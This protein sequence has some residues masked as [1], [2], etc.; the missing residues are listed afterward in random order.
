LAAPV[1][2]GGR[3]PEKLGNIGLFRQWETPDVQCFS[4][5]NYEIRQVS[6]VRK[7]RMRLRV[8]LTLMMV[9][10]LALAVASAGWLSY[11]QASTGIY[12]LMHQDLVKSAQVYGEMVDLYLDQRRAD[13][14]VMAKHPVLRDPGAPAAEKAAVLRTYLQAYDCYHTISVTDTAGI[15]IADTSGITGDDKSDLGWFQEARDGKVHISSIRMSRDLGLPIVN[16]AAPMYDDTGAFTGAITARLN[17]DQTIWK[18]IDGYAERSKAVDRPSAY[19]YLIDSQG[20]IIAHP[21]KEMIL[22]DDLR[23]LGVPELAE[24]GERMIRGETGVVA[25]TFRG[26]PKHVGFA[27]LDGYGNYR[28]QG[29]SI[30]AGVNDEEFLVP[31]VAI[32]NGAFAVG[33][34]VLLVGLVAAGWFAVRLTAPLRRMIEE[35]NRVGEGDLTRRLETKSTDEIGELAA[36]FNQMVDALRGLVARVGESSANL[37][38]QSQEISASSEEVASVMDQV[39]GSTTQVAATAEQ[40]SSGAQALVQ[41]AEKMKHAALGG[42]KHV[43]QSVKTIESTQEATKRI[44]ASTKELEQ[45][46]GKVSQITRVITD[47]ADQTNLLALNAAIEAARAGEQG[48]G[49]AVV[50]EEVRKLAEQSAGAAKEISQIVSEIGRGMQAVSSSTDATA[51]A[52]AKG[53]ETAR[54]AGDAFKEIVKTVRE[55]IEMIEQ[56]AQ[57]SKQTSNATQNLAASVEEV[58]STME[59]LTSSSQELARLA[60]EL[61]VLVRRFRLD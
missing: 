3:K 26:V 28:G 46:T 34:A 56:I 47:I 6:A 31:L 4:V 10:L 41:S 55:N 20:I 57:G 14:E 42:N 49:F 50:A 11:R 36:A 48:R 61:A 22:R 25:Y 12:G 45:R 51:A 19:A 8:K 17:L 13:V 52:V 37:A 58:S 33:G 54:Q 53:V 5:K 40:A 21:D 38:A 2:G 29:W 15:Q 7:L 24:A 60:D 16:F 1:A 27:P 39:A 32:R 23:Q 35:A 30:A 43:F 59:E 18:I 9:F 44:T